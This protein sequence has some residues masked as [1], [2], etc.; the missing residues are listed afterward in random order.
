M[1]IIE[2]DDEEKLGALMTKAMREGNNI[3][4]IIMIM[5]RITNRLRIVLIYCIQYIY[6]YMIGLEGLVI[7]DRKTIYEPNARHWIKVKKV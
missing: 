3:H 5:I 1:T 2:N 7:K 4:I 6:I